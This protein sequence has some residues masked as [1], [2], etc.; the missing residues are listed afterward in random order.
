MLHKSEE[1]KVWA[2]QNSLSEGCIKGDLG[3]FS[4]W[5]YIENV[6]FGLVKL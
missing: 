1:Q 3:W 6:N 4:G 5:C 2:L